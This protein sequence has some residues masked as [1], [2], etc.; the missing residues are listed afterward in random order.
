MKTMNLLKLIR[1]LMKKINQKS[2]F[3]SEN[4]MYDAVLYTL[5]IEMVTFIFQLKTNKMSL[6]FVIF[7]HI[8]F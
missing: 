1:Q 3:L 5:F 7:S 8:Y 2:K 4:K 6:S